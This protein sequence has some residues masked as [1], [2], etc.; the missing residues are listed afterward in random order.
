M[1]KGLLIFKGCVRVAYLFIKKIVIDYFIIE[2]KEG[3]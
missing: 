2:K 1:I 3:L